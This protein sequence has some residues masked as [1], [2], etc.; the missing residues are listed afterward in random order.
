MSND[1]DPARE[2]AGATY[3][4]G[5]GIQGGQSQLPDAPQ[6]SGWGPRDNDIGRVQKADADGNVFVEDGVMGSNVMDTIT[7]QTDVFTAIRSTRGQ[8]QTVHEATPD[9]IVTVPGV[10]EM[11]LKSALQAGFASRMADGT[12]V[13][14]GG[15]GQRQQG[16]QEAPEGQQPKTQHPDLRTE[17][18]ADDVEMRRQALS[19]TL[20]PGTQ[21]KA[22]SDI[23]E[24]ESGDISEAVLNSL[25]SQVGLEPEQMLAEIAPV[26][27]AMQA[28][29]LQS[30]EMLGMPGQDVV[31]W[32]WQ[33]RP[34]MIKDAIKHHGSKFNTDGYKA[35]AFEWFRTADEHSPEML[36]DENSDFG[37]PVQRLPNGDIVATLPDGST[38]PWKSVVDLWIKSGAK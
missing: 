17:A 14:G 1:F 25:A 13:R 30:I 22:I 4:A 38:V 18:L 34:D 27:E 29:A 6:V 16:Q 31:N 9:S 24:S 35:L 11:S 23:A 15:Q 37:V 36:V 5:L 28:Q 8:P 33:H 19:M 2:T 10:G 32:A 12:Y 26:R 7:P 3:S 21:L 20:D